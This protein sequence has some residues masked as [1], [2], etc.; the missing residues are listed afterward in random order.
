MADTGV[1]QLQEDLH[2]AEMRV[3]DQEEEITRL[4]AELERR[5]FEPEARILELQDE[6]DQLKMIAGMCCC[7]PPNFDTVMQTVN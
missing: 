5:P 7:Y 2:A 1:M 3:A 4:K 6:I